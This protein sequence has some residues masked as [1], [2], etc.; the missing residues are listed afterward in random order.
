MPASRAGL[1][2]LLYFWFIAGIPDCVGQDLLGTTLSE[3]RLILKVTTLAR[4]REL[5]SGLGG[6]LVRGSRVKP[7]HTTLNG[8]PSEEGVL[9]RSS[10]E[11]G[12]KPVST[13]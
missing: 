5:Y 13:G 7:T 8:L 4:R 9:T 1:F 11:R 12:S 10:R 6:W 2:P 3:M